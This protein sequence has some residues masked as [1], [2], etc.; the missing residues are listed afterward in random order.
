V[1]YQAAKDRTGKLIWSYTVHSANSTDAGN[2][3]Q[4]LALVSITLWE[5]ESGEGNR[6]WSG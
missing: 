3:Q 2:F 5:V 1:I 4:V 6:L